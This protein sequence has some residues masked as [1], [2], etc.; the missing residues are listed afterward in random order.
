MVNLILEFM[1]C[2][3]CRLSGEFQEY[4]NPYSESTWHQ[5]MH[6]KS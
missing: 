5:N 4:C 1:N 2:G 3:E 6:L